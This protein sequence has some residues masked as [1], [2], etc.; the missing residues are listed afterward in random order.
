MSCEESGEDYTRSSMICTPHQI[1]SRRMRRG[2]HVAR[3][4]TGGVHTGF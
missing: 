1:K 3:M 2:G 4:G